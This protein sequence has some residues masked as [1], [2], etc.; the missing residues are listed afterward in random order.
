MEIGV[1]ITV[2]NEGPRIDKV[3]K[4]LSKYRVIVVNDGSIDDTL[5][6]VKKYKNVELISYTKNKGKGYALQ[7]GFARARKL[8]FDTL[9]LMDGDGQHNPAD[10]PKFVKKI[11]DGFN[12]VLGS[13][14]IKRTKIPF[15]RRIILRCGCLIE[16][17]VIGIDLTDVHNGYRAINK[18]AL[19]KIKLT[20][21]RMAYASELMM[22]I[23]RHD[24]SYSEIPIKVKYTPEI[25]DQGTSSIF[26]GFKILFRIAL[27]KIRRF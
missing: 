21:N 5:S 8:K 13:R 20:E 17:L 7:R 3:L 6:K 11:K 9:I 24:L 15:F 4:K 12:V 23:I 1:L 26:T 25:M 27:L 2:Y 19:N 22:E 16:K 10:I 14:F 18:N